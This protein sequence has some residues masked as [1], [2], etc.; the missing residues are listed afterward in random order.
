MQLR[1]ETTT[2]TLIVDFQGT[3]N[4]RFDIFSRAG[5]VEMP[6]QPIVGPTRTFN[7]LFVDNSRSIIVLLNGRASFLFVDQ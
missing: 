4:I 7:W 2:E 1:C 3:A 6:Y 5:Q